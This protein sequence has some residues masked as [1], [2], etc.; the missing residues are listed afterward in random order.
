[1]KKPT[2]EEVKQYC[3]ERKNAV[4]PELFFDHYTANG[5]V[6]GRGK[7]LKDWK[8]AVRTWERNELGRKREAEKKTKA[9]PRKPLTGKQARFRLVSIYKVTAARDWSDERCLKEYRRLAFKEP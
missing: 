4:D 5:W 9:A 1:M 3:A 7:P 6:Q 8:A 2:L